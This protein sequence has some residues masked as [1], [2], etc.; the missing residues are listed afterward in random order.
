M[1][2]NI[3]VLD[4]SR[5]L[6]GPL[7]AM[8]LA[9]LGADVIKV[10]I[11]GR[12]DDTRNWGP[13]F[14]ERG[15]SA[16]FRS[17]NRNKL[18]IALDFNLTT[19]KDLL[20]KLISEADV[21]VDNFLPGVL[22]RYG[23]D[24]D[25]LLALNPRLIWCTISGFGPDSSRPGYDF[26][27]QAESGW[28]AITGE[29]DGQPMKVGVALVDV[30][31]AKDAVNAILG[32]LLARERGATTQRHLQISLANSAAAALVNV[33]QNVIVSGK[34]AARWGNAHPNLVP[35]QLFAAADR[36]IVIAVGTDSQWLTLTQVL[37][38]NA[39]HDDPTLRTNP[40]RLAARERIVNT[41]SER[42]R[43]RDADHWLELLH[44]ARVPAGAVRTV[45]E[46]LRVLESDS[47][48]GI[49]PALPDRIRHQPP[50]L[51]EHGVAIRKNYWSVFTMLPIL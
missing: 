8:T 31:T 4:L 15:L 25:T 10:E 34:D 33:A 48:T 20:L 7:A 42:L 11:P 38:L 35:Y 26:V 49:F 1:L 17:I 21:V 41:I 19:D 47:P 22:H 14:D 13:P 36:S 12:G 18:S 32:A 16:Y 6:A 24:T 37:G 2:K 44:D 3:R 43:T 27:L 39:E 29:P 5:V 46:A 28:M 40:G 9:E 50:L 45:Q 51:N 30:V 23:I